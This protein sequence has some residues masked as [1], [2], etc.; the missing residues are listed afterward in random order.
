[1][2]MIIYTILFC[3]L[4]F[5]AC[6]TTV[7]TISPV[8]GLAVPL[9][10]LTGPVLRHLNKSTYRFRTTS[11]SGIFVSILM[12]RRGVEDSTIVYYGSFGLDLKSMWTD[13]MNAMFSSPNSIIDSGDISINFE[14]L[15]AF[16]GQNAFLT[17]EEEYFDSADLDKQGLLDVYTNWMSDTDAVYPF[18][19]TH[20]YC[21]FQSVSPGE[22]KDKADNTDHDDDCITQIRRGADEGFRDMCLLAKYELVDDL[23]GNPPETFVLNLEIP[24]IFNK[25]LT[26]KQLMSSK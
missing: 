20:Y 10:Q 25:N 21:R 12:S 15:R 4:F 11:S 8:I 5:S 17:S 23:E 16:T 26:A 19:P 1:M 24:I 2:R 6:T 9:A 14:G 13:P 7:T 22:L 18:T 3:I